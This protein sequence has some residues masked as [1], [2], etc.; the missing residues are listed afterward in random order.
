MIGAGPPL[1]RRINLSKFSDSPNDINNSQIKS[2]V[3]P[4]NGLN[5][6]QRYYKILEVRKTLPAWMERERF[7]E[8]LARNNTLIL[9]GE[10][11]SGKTTQIPQFALSASWLGNKSIAVTQPRRVAAISV[12]A[13]VSEE[14]DVELGSF[15]GYSIRFEEK[16]CPSTRLKFLTDGML[17]R[18]AQSDN[19]LSKYGLIVLDEAH[20]RTISTDILF[21]IV[22]GVIEK[23]TDLKVVVMS[24]TLDAGKFRS[25]FKHAE[26][27][28]IPGKMYPVEIIYS[29]KPEKDYLK[30]AV[31]KVVEIHRN[32]PH[33]DILV[34]LTGEE[35]IENGKLLIEKALLEYDDIDTQLFVFPLY[36]SLP[37][38]QQS[39]VFET[40]NGRKCILS[41]NIAETSLTIDGIVYVID[42]GFSKQKV[43]NPRTRMES[44]LVSQISKASANQRTGRAGRTRPGKCFRLYTEFSYSTLVESTFPEILRSNISSV[45]LSL[46]KLGIDD[47]VHFD[48]MDPPAPETMMR[49]LEELNFLGALDDEGELTS[50]G[51]IMADFPIEPQLART[52]I[53]SGHYKCTSSVLSIIAMLSVPYCFIRPRDRANQADEMKSQFSHEGGDHMTLLNV[54][55]DFVK[56]CDVTPD[57]FDVDTCKSYCNT[58]FL[59]FRSFSNAIN[60]RKQ[61]DKLLHKH[62]LV[63]DDNNREESAIIDAFLNGFFQQVALRSS[64]GHYLTLRDGQ[65][66]LLHPSTVL[67][68]HPE[69][70]I[71]HEFVLT[72]KSYIRTVSAIKGSK[73]AKLASEY[74]QNIELKG[75]V[76][77]K[78][79]SLSR[80]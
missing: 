2:N 74:L 78:V 61:L 5:Y 55:N 21:G 57:Y 13:R 51:S 42:T 60:V 32:E 44:L 15:V 24:A 33:G 27:L 68:T 38:A 58:N 31:A 28:M 75:E 76:L 36:S 29:N 73:L 67:L 49:A 69:W 1:K 8:L 47:L 77:H 37:S 34:F 18:E 11:G 4:Y 3:N 65:M 62:N 59:N 16:S 19:L 53:D 72:T 39:K 48:F 40:V 30:S 80:F 6:S 22:K 70:V 79:R 35:E 20:E 25:Y 12:A 26:V 45:I 64:K 46:K 50:K 14:L 63:N 7:L 10:T 52:L 43:Y 66:V 71:Y 23:R 17:L 9:I 56:K 41:T 54:F